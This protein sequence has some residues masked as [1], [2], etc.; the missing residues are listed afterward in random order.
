MPVPL[1]ARPGIGVLQSAGN[2]FEE[3]RNRQLIK[4][5]GSLT[6]Y[7]PDRTKSNKPVKAPL[8]L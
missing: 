7:Q 2:D 1:Q 5:F 4:A 6:I 3:E 8:E